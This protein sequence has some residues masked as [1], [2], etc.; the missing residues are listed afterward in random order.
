MEWLNRYN[1][2]TAQTGQQLTI[3]TVRQLDAAG[4]SP[5]GSDRLIAYRR[6]PTIIK[7]HIPMRHRFLPVWQTGPL[8]FDIP[9]IFRIGGAEVRRPGAMRYM[10]GI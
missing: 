6:D 5:L 7:M 1:V 9:G 10:D 8:V 2:Y 4:T 3:R